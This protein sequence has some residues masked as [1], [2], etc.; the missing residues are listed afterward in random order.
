M[1]KNQVIDLPTKKNL[2][3]WKAEQEPES[4]S[5]DEDNSD[6][7]TLKKPKHSPIGQLMQSP[8][9]TG[10]IDLT[11]ET[12]P[13]APTP[14]SSKFWFQGSFEVS[15]RKGKTC[16]LALRNYH[17]KNIR[18]E[19]ECICDCVIY[20]IQNL[21]QCQCSQI[22]GFDRPLKP[23]RSIILRRLS[24]GWYPRPLEGK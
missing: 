3:Q 9:M 16:Y 4:D 15:N 24:I 11:S 6:E 12:P 22:E 1:I 17:R 19:N 2:Q 7:P 18:M 21:L 13:R 14:E 5:D 10:T 8:T 23:F 20:A